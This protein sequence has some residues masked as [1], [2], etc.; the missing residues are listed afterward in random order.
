MAG[1]LAPY[2]ALYVPGPTHR[3]ARAH[4]SRARPARNAHGADTPYATRNPVRYERPVACRP[5]LRRAETCARLTTSA[6]GAHPRHPADAGGGTPARPP[7]SRGITRC[8][9]L[10]SR[11]EEGRR[12]R[13][14]AHMKRSCGIKRCGL[15]C[16]DA[17]EAM[18][19]A[20]RDVRRMLSSV[21]SERD[22][23]GHSLDGSH[24]ARRGRAEGETVPRKA[25][26]RRV[27]LFQTR[28]AG[29]RRP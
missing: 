6:A 12:E 13:E 23:R 14:D 24:R 18:A 15:A 27:E 4:V 21:S 20:D 3:P 8:R 16:E 17:A 28:A 1:L 5:V 19:W 10:N 22:R 11:S 7:I 29:G 2:P 26:P 9:A 25:S